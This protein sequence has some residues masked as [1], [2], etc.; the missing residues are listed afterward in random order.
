MQTLLGAQLLSDL[1]LARIRGLN[2]SYAPPNLPV[3]NYDQTNQT[4]LRNARPFIYRATALV[5]S[6]LAYQGT[7]ALNLAVGF[8]NHATLIRYVQW[9]DLATLPTAGAVPIQSIPV[10]PTQ[11][12]SWSPSQ[13]GLIFE[14]GCVFGLS[15]TAMTYTAS[16][17]ADLYMRMEG[18][19]L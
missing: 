14:N 1:R 7:F 4:I 8:N 2:R 15:S 13:D 6:A 11:E 3:S 18:L 17:T 5:I 12:F 16:L 10:N 9:F 19:A